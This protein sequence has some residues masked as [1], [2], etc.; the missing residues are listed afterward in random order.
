MAAS[1]LDA[2]LPSRPFANWFNQLIGAKAGVVWQLTECGERIL[3]PSGAG[4]DLPACA[5]VNA[6][7]QDGRKVFVVISVG[8]F[9]KGMV[10]KPAFYSAVVER[11]ERLYQIRRLR[12]LAETLRAPDPL[13]ESAPT[14]SAKPQIAALPAV[15]VDTAPIRAL[16]QFP[17][18]S[19]PSSGEPP[20]FVGLSQ[21]DEPPPPRRDPEKVSEGVSLGRA[22]SKVKPLYPPNARKM[23]A[24][25]MVEV[26]I[27]ISEEGRVVEATAISGHIA[28]RSAAVEA[29]RQWVFQPAILSGAP[30]RVK[31]V[32]TFTFAPNAK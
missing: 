25:G 12:D 1:D 27:T 15:T 11:D 8:T 7:L 24:A 4:P 10:G 14:A 16:M 28:L 32:L 22:I 30:I 2:E 9:R 31:S 29:A 19:S 13:P 6:N 26:Q 18:L 3:S 23:N 5:E 21:A 20:I 17:A